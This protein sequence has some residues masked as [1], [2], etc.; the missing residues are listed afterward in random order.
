MITPGKIKGLIRILETI[1]AIAEAL[2]NVISRKK[3]D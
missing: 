3:H 2:V 1:A